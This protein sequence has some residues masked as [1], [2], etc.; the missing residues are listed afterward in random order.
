MQ[1][2]IEQTGPT[3]YSEPNIPA[4][5]IDQ[6]VYELILKSPNV[7]VDTVTADMVLKNLSRWPIS[8]PMLK[9]GRL[10]YKSA[11]KS[12]PLKTRRSTG[13]NHLTRH[14]PRVFKLMRQLTV[15]IIRIASS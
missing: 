8:S 6:R 14:S 9:S 4:M 2:D 12:P 3:K 7:N 5:P 15:K 13:T 11:I 1:T 10:R